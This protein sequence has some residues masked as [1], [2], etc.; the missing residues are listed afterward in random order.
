MREETLKWRHDLSK[1][2]NSQA[3]FKDSTLSNSQSM[4]EMERL[5]TTA[6]YARLLKLLE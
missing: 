4:Q 1:S 3:L 6:K 2:K 5:F